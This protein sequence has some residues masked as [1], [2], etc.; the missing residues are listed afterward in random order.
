MWMAWN[1]YPNCGQMWVKKTRSIHVHKLDFIA[2]ND[3][4]WV[5]WHSWSLKISNPK[6]SVKIVLAPELGLPNTTAKN[7]YLVCFILS[8]RLV[9]TCRSLQL[10]T[11]YPTLIKSS[12][13]RTM[14]VIHVSMCVCI[15]F[16]LLSTRSVPVSNVR[17]MFWEFCQVW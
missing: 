1:S 11:V 5:T 6:H 2:F 10:C 17:R 3:C 12:I 4:F 16:R 8:C 7:P 15:C 14:S 13:S 9:L